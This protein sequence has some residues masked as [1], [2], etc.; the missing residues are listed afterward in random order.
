MILEWDCADERRNTKVGV[1]RWYRITRSC[2]DSARAKHY[3]ASWEEN[4]RRRNNFAIKT[5]GEHI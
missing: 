5:Q 2:H 3:T 4:R 1:G